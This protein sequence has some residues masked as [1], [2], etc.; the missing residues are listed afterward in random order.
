V[1]KINKAPVILL[2]FVIKISYSEYFLF[3]QNYKL[4]NGTQIATKSTNSLET[5]TIWIWNKKKFHNKTVLA[6]FALH[7]LQ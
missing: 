3:S 5:I 7:I 2:V 1:S 6:L 4:L